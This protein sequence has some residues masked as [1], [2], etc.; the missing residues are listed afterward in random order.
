MIKESTHNTPHEI[1][2]IDAKW[3]HCMQFVED[4]NIGA[5]ENVVRHWTH[6]EWLVFTVAKDYMFSFQREDAFVESDNVL[7]K[8]IKD[9]KEGELRRRVETFYFLMNLSPKAIDI[10][11]VFEPANS[12]QTVSVH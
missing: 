6:S 2:E 1:I 5:I 8:M 12:T 7:T 11:S 10:I 4:E 9:K 3:K